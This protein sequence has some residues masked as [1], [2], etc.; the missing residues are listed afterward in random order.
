MRRPKKQL[1]CLSGKVL[2]D[3]LATIGGDQAIALL[4]QVTTDAARE[5]ELRISAAES[6]RA[7]RLPEAQTLLIQA[8][9][10]ETDAVV[11]EAIIRAL[12]QHQSPRIERAL[13]TFLSEPREAK[14]DIAA[15][16]LLLKL[17]RVQAVNLIR[18]RLTP[19]TSTEQ[20]TAYVQIL[21]HDRDS[22]S[23]QP[24]LQLFSHPHMDTLQRP[25]IH[26]LSFMQA[27][28]AVPIFQTRLEQ[29]HWDA[30]LQ[31]PLIQALAILGDPSTATSLKRYYQQLMRV[32]E[33]HRAAHPKL[34]YHQLLAGNLRNDPLP[35][36]ALYR[37][38]FKQRMA[39]ISAIIKLDPQ[40][41]VQLLKSVA[42]GRRDQPLT[43]L[44]NPVR[45]L[46]IR[47]LAHINSE[48]TAQFLL[49]ANLL[50]DADPTIRSATL[51]TLA[52]LYKTKLRTLD[53]VE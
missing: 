32:Y 33:R 23:V 52:P 3:H 36:I 4:S 1:N 8:L 35:A 42:T 44:D 45:R 30:P 11:Q 48:T 31:V 9:V 14:A 10:A 41:S 49:N 20:L 7:S 46:A 28:E 38:Y 26:A 21:G 2:T 16:R 27:K 29:G 12:H 19:T 40:G 24:L 15:L 37:A 43:E 6:L 53:I 13:L 39:L 22:Q 25:I 51:Y 50:H 34:S 47:G 5:K 18:Q 17:N